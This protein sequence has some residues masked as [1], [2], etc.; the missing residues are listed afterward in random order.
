MANVWTL[1]VFGNQ[2]P[3]A[4]LNRAQ[5]AQLSQVFFTCDPL[6]PLT[7]VNPIIF[8]AD[9]HGFRPVRVSLSSSQR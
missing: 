5:Q 9:P 2:L 7:N 4:T 8:Q 1:P 3:R 6:P